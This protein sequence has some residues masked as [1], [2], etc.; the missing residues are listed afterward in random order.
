MFKFI[1]LI[2]LFFICILADVGAFGNGYIGFRYWTPPYGQCFPWSFLPLLSTDVLQI[3]TGPIQ[4]GING[5]GQVFVL[6]AAYY[7]GTEIVSVAAGES[8]NPQRDVPRVSHWIYFK[9]KSWLSPKATKSILYRILVVF[10]GMS[11]FQ[12]LICPSTSDD[13]VHPDSKTASS[14]FTIGFTLAGWKSS[15]HFVNT[16][17]L[18]AFVS[19]ANGVVYIQSRTLYSLALKQK[20]PSLFA[21]TSSRGGEFTKTKNQVCQWANDH[22]VPYPA[23]IFSN[24]WGFLGLMSLTTTA[25]SL[26]SYFT[27][28]GGT[29][30]YIA[31]ATI[32][33]VQLRVRAAAKKQNIDIQTF[34]FTAPGH[35]LVYWGNFF[36]NIFLL[37]IQG[38]TVFETPFNYQSFIASY[39]SIPVFF[40]LFFGY[41]WWFKTKWWVRVILRTSI[42]WFSG[43]NLAHIFLGCHSM[44]LTSRADATG[45]LMKRQQNQ[46]LGDEGS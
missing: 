45:P 4:N 16:I 40:A 35:T 43:V 42:Y 30:A 36:F 39:I 13:L 29:A 8:K 22:L 20:A 38:F 7:V 27:S 23:I 12:G 24:M 33:F 11:F 10:I 2:V 28:F 21:I 17:I 46:D 18:I 3:I 19:A 32:T 25:G 5:F 6:A 34:P 44:R 26:F 1:S 15:G 31:W 14:P 37:L 9:G 41:K